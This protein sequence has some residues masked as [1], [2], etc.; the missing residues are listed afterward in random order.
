MKTTFFINSLLAICLVITSCSNAQ[1]NTLIPQPVSIQINKNKSYRLS[2]PIIISGNTNEAK[3]EAEYLGNK[4]RPATG[5]SYQVVTHGDIELNIND[6]KDATLGDEGYTLNVTKDGVTINANTSAGLFY[7]IQTLLQLLPKE[8]ESTTTKYANWVIPEATITDYPRFAWRG[9]MLDVSRHFMSKEDVKTYIDLMSRY[10]YNIFHWHLTDDHGWR[11]EIKSYPKLTTVGACRV[12]RTGKFGELEPPKDGEQATDCG[13]YT[14]EDIKEVVAYA[15]ERHIQIMPEIDVPGHS[16]AAIAAYPELSCTKDP[17]SYVSPGNKFSKWE[18]NGNFS[19]II[20]NSL[21]PSDENTY[22][23]LDAVYGEVA[24][25]FPYPYIHMG[26]DECYHGYWHKDAGC[27]QLMQKEG[28]KDEKELQSYFVKRVEKILTSKGKKLIGWDEILM[29]G[30]APQ[31]AVMSWTGMQGGIEAAKQGHN[32]VMTPN[33]NVYIDLP[34]GDISVEPD[35]LT[36]GTV[37]LTNAYN[38][39]P[40]PEGVDAKYILGGQANLW[41]E[42]VPNLR[43]AEYMTYPRAW[44]LSEVYWSPKEKRNWDNFIPRMEYHMERADI[45]EVNYARSAYDA[46]IKPSIENG[47]LKVEITTE[48]KGLDIYYTLDGNDATSKSKKYTQPFIVNDNT[49]F[50]VITY[51]GKNVIGKMI[52][53]PA[54]EL[55]KRAK[56]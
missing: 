14:Q 52:T 37:R 20:D 16:A 17:K 21:N 15:A 43:H 54:A 27:Q 40:I 22:K 51:R 33:Q 38:F 49:V 11:I 13:Y 47:K 39:E 19:M 24:A 18:G 2:N 29:G 4:L 12:P 28:L 35:A 53:L 36:Y 26:G 45:A 44:A 34:Q 56:R 50:K 31:A 23:F 25:L 42:K 10:K 30:L 46:I 9:L 1:T 8:I 3:K 6:K 7:G 48:I 41:T 32:V 5:F 55:Q